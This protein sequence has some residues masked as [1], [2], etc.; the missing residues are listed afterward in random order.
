MAYFAFNV[1]LLLPESQSQALLAKSPAGTSGK[2]W[3]LLMIPVLHEILQL[4]SDQYL[5][6]VV[7]I[8]LF[9]HLINWRKGQ[10]VERLGA[11][12]C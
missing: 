7:N 4:L 2:Y 3:N 9:V 5:G 12:T 10:R 8:V 6:Q 1:H 11:L